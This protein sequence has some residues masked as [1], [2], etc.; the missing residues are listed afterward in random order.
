MRKRF[1]A[2]P[3]IAHLGIALWAHLTKGLLRAYFDRPGVRSN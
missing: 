2:K 3:G 1:R